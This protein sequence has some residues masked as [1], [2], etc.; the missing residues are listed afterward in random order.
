MRT[1]AAVELGGTKTL[2]ATGWALA[3]LEG[4]NRIPTTTPEETVGA[5][6]ESLS[7]AELGAVGVASFGPVELRPEHPRHGTIL[8]TPKAGWPGTDVMAPFAELGAPVALDTDVNAA[9]LAEWKWGAAKGLGTVAYVTVGTGVG[10]GVLVHGEPLH[11]APHPEAGHVAVE[12]ARGDEHPGSCPFHGDCLEGMAAG[13]S[14]EARFGRPPESLGPESRERA[15]EL[16]A[17]YLAQGLRS[18]VYVA[19]PERIVVG[20][21]VAG[22]DGLHELAGRHLFDMLAG[23][24]GVEEHDPGGFVVPPRLGGISGLAGALAMAQRVVRP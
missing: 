6:L 15:T 22:L 5:V 18:L 8:A 10:A 7:G 24:P 17:W 16:A 12:R 1:L 2:V 23:Y 20:G 19:A 4:A 14:L 9:A 11:G 3:D 21:G 13:P